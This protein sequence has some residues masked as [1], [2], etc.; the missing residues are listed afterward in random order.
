MAF[1]LTKNIHPHSSHKHVKDMHVNTTLRIHFSSTI[2]ARLK[3]I[4]HPAGEAVETQALP[5]LTGGNANWYNSPE[6]KLAIFNQIIHLLTFGLSNLT[7]RD[8]S[9]TY[10]SNNMK[11]Q[12]H[13]VTYYSTVIA[14]IWE[15]VVYHSELFL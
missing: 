2:L 3:S 11:T 12:K 15:M 14:K 7:S 1:K 13:K 9:Q 6:G 10:I 4:T 8:F 5:H